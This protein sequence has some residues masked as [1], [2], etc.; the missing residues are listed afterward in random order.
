MANTNLARFTINSTPSEDSNG[1]RGY[2]AIPNEELAITLEQNPALG[3]NSVTYEL[4]DSSNPFGSGPLNSLF[5]T[6]QV[7]DE[8]GGHSVTTSAPNTTFHV[9]IAGST[10]ISTYT[11]RATVS[12]ASGTQ[13]F[14]RQIAVRKNG[15]RMTVPAETAQYGQRGWSDALNELT[16]YVADGGLSVSLVNNTSTGIVSA[17]PGGLARI[18]HSDGATAGGRWDVLSKT[19]LDAAINAGAVDL[20][21]LETG[22][23]NYLIR[24]VGGVPAWSPEVTVVT[25]HGGLTGLTDVADH[26][27]Y[28]LVDGTRTL[29]GNQSF[30]SNAATNLSYVSF[31]TGGHPNPATAG[32]VRLTI[33]GS[34]L[35]RNADNTANVVLFSTDDTG[36]FMCGH[37]GTMSGSSNRVEWAA[38]DE[39]TWS[40]G[41]VDWYAADATQFSPVTA[42][43]GQ[44]NLGTELRRWGPSWF[45]Q[46]NVDYLSVNESASDPSI[47]AAGSGMFAKA[48]GMAVIGDDGSVNELLGNEGATDG[49]K[50]RLYQRAVSSQTTLGDYTIWSDSTLFGCTTLAGG[51]EGTFEGF[52]KV[53]CHKAYISLPSLASALKRIRFVVSINA[54]GTL[55][56][57][58]SLSESSI[59]NRGSSNFAGMSVSVD[60]SSGAF[61]VRLLSQPANSVCR[62]IL[63][64]E[65]SALTIPT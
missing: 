7:F 47:P 50:R 55:G 13:Y 58:S 4:Y 25:D 21:K 43:T 59:E 44:P 56:V 18:F 46:A 20:A 33:S 14:E 22:T 52:I 15:L 53:V 61:R 40:V 65:F 19:I 54:D 57:L 24:M 64:G 38:Y 11:L 48:A 29:T 27:G 10:E 51:E 12:T 49:A 23:N 32:S 39:H 42:K 35:T 60:V 30:G 26:P 2:D 34:I 62:V 41:G 31:A 28:L 37:T 5:D 6:D 1:D 63:E 9:T 8:G 3:V 17:Y 16:K 45:A 36:S